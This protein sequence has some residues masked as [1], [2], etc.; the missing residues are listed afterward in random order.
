MREDDRTSAELF[1]ELRRDPA[2]GWE[3]FVRRFA[4]LVHA[5]PRRLGLSEADAEEVAQATWLALHRHAQWVRDASSIGSWIVR[6]ATRE[7]WRLRRTAMRTADVEISTA[8]QRLRE[9]ES[10]PS[11]DEVAQ[12]LEG[13][14]LVRDAIGSLGPPCTALLRAL[15][16]E[17]K[18]DYR[19]ISEKLGMPMG[20]IGPTRARCLE[21]L[22]GRLGSAWDDAER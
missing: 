9:E 8:E 1:E 3:P 2:T 4:P 17:E 12:R 5:V 6:T 19:A 18:A 11:S 13:A 7:A 15:Y 14:Q 16:L 20:S 10:A 22:L 21:K